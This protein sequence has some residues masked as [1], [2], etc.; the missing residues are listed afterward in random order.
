MGRSAGPRSGARARG[1]DRRVRLGRGRTRS[2]WCRVHVRDGR[3]GGG[4][5]R[6]PPLGKARRAWSCAR[7]NALTKIAEFVQSRDLARMPD[8]RFDRVKR[9]VVDTWAAQTAGS[10]IASEAARPQRV[11]QPPRFAL[12]RSAEASAKAEGRA[13][14]SWFDTLTLSGLAEPLSDLIVSCA[15]ARCT[16]IDDI[17]LM[18]CTTPG[19]VVVPTAV[20]F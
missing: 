8:D 14:R 2:L 9:H 18:S 4:G 7:M 15:Q 5:D 20:T 3:C 11:D 6:A 17:H 10:R 19:S 1:C 13:P 16:E 12:R